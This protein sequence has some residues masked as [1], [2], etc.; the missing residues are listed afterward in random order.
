[1]SAIKR[2]CIP[3]S[4]T[5]PPAICTTTATSHP[6]SGR[7][8]PKFANAPAVPTGSS[9]L[10]NLNAGRMH[11]LGPKTKQD[12]ATRGNFDKVIFGC[13]RTFRSGTEQSVNCAPGYP[14]PWTGSV[15]PVLP[16]G[17]AAIFF[18]NQIAAAKKWGQMRLELPNA[19]KS[20]DHH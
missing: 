2:T 10:A 9:S 6:S 16:R 3:K 1:M 8:I 14:P 4:S 20:T 18:G 11:V 17:P 15:R 7:G 5:R 12:R 19:G 13:R